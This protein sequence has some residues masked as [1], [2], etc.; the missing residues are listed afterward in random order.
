MTLKSDAKFEEKLIYCSK[1]EK[2]LIN[3]D[4]STRNTQN[5]HFDCFLLCKVC[6]VWPKKLQRSYL[7]SLWE[8]STIWRKTYL[9]FGKW[10]EEFGKCS[11]DHSKVSKLELWWD[12]F[13]Q[14]RKWMSLKFTEELCVLTTKN[15]TKFEEEL[16]YRFKID[17]RNLT[18]FDPSPQKSQ[19]LAL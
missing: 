13:I 17:I 7:W 10:H 14:S 6:K 11:P 4:L 18:N 15:D 2:K 19:K 5:F 3:F 8:W 16:T 9:W 1:N 12:S